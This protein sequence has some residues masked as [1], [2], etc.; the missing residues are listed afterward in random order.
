VILLLSILCGES[1]IL[2]LWC[3]G[4]RCDMADNDED[5]GKGRRQ[6]VEDRRWSSIG[7]VLGL[8]RAQGDEE[9]MFLGLASEPRS[10]V[11]RFMPQNW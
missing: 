7:R 10:T 6:G 2:I 3:V 4:D 1:C 11:S 9:R 8:H 5:L